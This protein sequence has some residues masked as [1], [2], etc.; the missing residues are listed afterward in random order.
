MYVLLF[1]VLTS[2]KSYFKNNMISKCFFHLISE[3]FSK[4]W[5][6]KKNGIEIYF[7]NFFKNIFWLPWNHILKSYYY[8]KIWSRLK[9]EI[10][11]RSHNMLRTPVTHQIVFQ[12]VSWSNESFSRPSTK[13]TPTFW[14][15]WFLM[16]LLIKRLFSELCRADLI[17]LITLTVGQVGAFNIPTSHWWFSWK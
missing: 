16:W 1:S 9:S 13:K 14:A 3:L 2:A 12:V 4:L 6:Q 8:F 10:F 7:L 17:N 11:C 15:P 5:F